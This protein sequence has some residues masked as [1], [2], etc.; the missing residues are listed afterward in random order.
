MNAATAARMLVARFYDEHELSSLQAD[1]KDLLVDLLKYY[2]SPSGPRS[3]IS[4]WGP[5]LNFI[6]SLL[7][8]AC[9]LSFG[10]K[11]NASGFTSTIGQSLCSLYISPPSSQ[12]DRNRRNST[13]IRIATISI[14][15]SGLSYLKER[16]EDILNSIK[17][18]YSI[19]VSD[20]N[21]SSSNHQIIAVASERNESEENMGGEREQEMPAVKTSLLSIIVGSLI[22][23]LQSLG[24]VSN[25]QRLQNL[26]T[27]IQDIHLFFFLRYG[28]SF[29]ISV[30]CRYLSSLLSLSF[31]YLDIALRLAN[32]ELTSGV[33]SGPSPSANEESLRQVRLPQRCPS[34]PVT[35]LSSPAIQ[36]AELSAGSSLG[37]PLAVRHEGSA[38]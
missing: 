4:L 28:R 18:F 7:F 13:I 24:G 33:K 6:A 8:F 27:L 30:H 2:S 15:Y 38:H 1:C 9:S 25:A 3:Q 34:F 22:R 11:S 10:V 32:V 36:G 12:L 19:I 16:S 20:E 5:E 21:L 26:Q 17:E 23:S 31:R 35:D 29:I 37:V 14:L